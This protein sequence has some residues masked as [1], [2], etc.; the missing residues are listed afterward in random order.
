MKLSGS[1]LCRRFSKARNVHYGRPGPGSELCSC[2]KSSTELCRNGPPGRFAVGG[3]RAE[4]LGKL[5]KDF[6]WNCETLNLIS[7]R[8]PSRKEKC[9][10]G[11]G[12]AERG[13]G[14]E[15]EDIPRIL[16]PSKRPRKIQPFRDDEGTGVG[17]VG[18]PIESMGLPTSSTLVWHRPRGDGNEIIGVHES[19]T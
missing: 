12:D 9:C 15:T 11:G 6:L 5:K 3:G 13:L 10:S 8:R 4:G 16:R 14:M 19:I 18:S 2:D 17:E 1:F 7:I